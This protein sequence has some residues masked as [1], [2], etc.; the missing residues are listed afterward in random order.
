[1]GRLEGGLASVQTRVTRDPEKLMAQETRKDPRAKVLT[2][3]VRYKSAT[4]DEFIEHHSHDVSRGGMFIKTPSPFPPGTLLKF[5]VKIA[6]EQKVIQGVGRVVWKRES[7]TSER[8]RPNG[9]GVKFIK[10]DDASRKIIDQLVNSRADAGAAYEAG[11]GDGGSAKTAPAATPAA[12]MT[13][14][15]PET[16]SGNK[17]PR[18]ATMIGLGSMGAHAAGAAKLSESASPPVAE[19]KAP[20]ASSGG[21]FPR[22]DSEADMPPPEDRTVMKQAAELL[23]DA[24]REAGGSMDDVGTKPDVKK[25]ELPESSREYASEQETLAAVPK[26]KSDPPVTTEKG[27]RTLRSDSPKSEKKPEPKP[28]T[29]QRPAVPAAAA[30]PERPA[31]PAAAAAARPVSTRPQ[32]ILSEAPA[33]GGGGRIMII[34]AGIAVA[35]AAVFFLTKKDPAAP[36]PEPPAQTTPAATPPSPPVDVVKPPEAPTAAPLQAPSAAVAPSAAPTPSATTTP[37]AAATPSAALVPVAKPAPVAPAP[38]PVP[39]APRPK[40]KPAPVAAEPGTEPAPAN[41]APA[42]EPKP[43]EP[44]PAPA[45]KPKPAEPSGDNPY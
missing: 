20:A 16:G 9:M 31:A 25:V 37:S 38:R 4:L 22:S 27:P 1:L 32:P 17:A 11:G 24:L 6:D 7:E 39:A 10:I 23:K 33:E 28:A 5:E 30:R 40:P 45:P 18:K 43:A 3:T 36:A 21:F 35:A 29:G 13:P 15:L 12:A 44:A 19:P 34:L 26:P 8:E 41:P 14:G 2:M 42:A